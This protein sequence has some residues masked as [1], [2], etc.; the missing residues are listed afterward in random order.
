MQ[1]GG[2]LVRVVKG[3]EISGFQP[4][5]KFLGEIGTKIKSN[6]IVVEAK[7]WGGGSLV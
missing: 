1:V 7:G 4:Q 3:Q 2:E 6:L 5:P